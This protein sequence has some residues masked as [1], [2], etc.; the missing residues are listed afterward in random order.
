MRRNL[1][2]FKCFDV[3]KKDG[4]I[5]MQVFGQNN[6]DVSSYIDNSYNLNGVRYEKILLGENLQEIVDNFKSNV[7]ILISKF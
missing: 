2:I 4:Q 3:F 6:Y 5:F 1:W 7:K